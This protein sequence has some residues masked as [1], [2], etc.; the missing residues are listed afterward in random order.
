VSDGRSRPWTSREIKIGEGAVEQ[1]SRNEGGNIACKA[2]FWR[3]DENPELKNDL[4]PSLCHVSNMLALTQR[5]ISRWVRCWET[6]LERA[7]P[8]LVGRPEKLP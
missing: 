2:N 8:Y 6:A 1:D 3:R 4:H 5:P 7:I